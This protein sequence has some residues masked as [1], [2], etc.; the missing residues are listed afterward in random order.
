MSILVGGHIRLVFP[1]RKLYL[2][3]AV[4]QALGLKPQNSVHADLMPT[5]ITGTEILNKD[6][7]FEFRKGPVFANVIGRQIVEPPI[8]KLL[9]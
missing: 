3:P 7:I 8:Y 9:Y 4:S 6:R 1:L 2:L 5:D